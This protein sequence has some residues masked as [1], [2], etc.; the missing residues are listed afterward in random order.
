M[1]NSELLMS[2]ISDSGLKVSFIAAKLGITR[3]G[4][5]KKVHNQSLFNQREIYIL[6]QLLGIKTL[7]EI[8]AI[9]FNI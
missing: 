9:F 7:E 2:K 8:K 1:N 4:L 3:S 6:C 5:Y